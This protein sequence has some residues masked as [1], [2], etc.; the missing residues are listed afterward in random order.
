MLK[1]WDTKLAEQY[2]TLIPNCNISDAP[3]L[4]EICGSKTVFAINGEN[5]IEAFAAMEDAENGMMEISLLC[6]DCTIKEHKSLISSLLAECARYASQHSADAV[7]KVSTV[8]YG[9]I[10]PAEQIGYKRI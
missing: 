3:V 10:I 4:K 2:M 6:V 8:S 1:S 9:I 5:G 7:F